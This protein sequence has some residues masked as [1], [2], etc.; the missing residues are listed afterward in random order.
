MEFDKIIVLGDGRILEEGT[1][2]E[3]LQNKGYYYEQ[4]EM[5]R[6]E[7]SQINE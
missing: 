5:Q 3:L 2:L 6:V 7:E 4:Y 1:Q